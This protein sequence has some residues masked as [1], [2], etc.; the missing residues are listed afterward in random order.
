MK[1]LYPSFGVLLVDDEKPWLRSLRIALERN[2]GINNIYMCDDSREVIPLL[3]RQS[4]G[5]IL[6][7]LTMPYLTGEKLLD[8]INKDFP[9]ITVIIISGMNQLEIA[10]Q[11]MKNGA[12]DYF[13][14]TIEEERLIQGVRHAIQMH[15]LTYCQREIT[16]RLLTGKLEN[17]EAFS[18]IITKN[19][20]MFSIFQYIEAI[21][22]TNQPVLIT[23]E[24]GSGKELVSQALHQLSQKKGKLVS[25][26][27]AGLDDNVFA[28]TLFGHLK[29][30][31]TGAD[32]ARKGIIEEATGGTL[33]LD[34][35][36]DLSLSSQVK[37]LRLLQEGEYFPLGSD[38]AKRSSVRVILA[39]HKDLKKEQEAGRFRKDLY[40]RL[41]THHVHI[42]ALRDRKDD[43]P[44]LLDHFLKEASIELKKTKPGYPR[45]LAVLLS[46]HNFPGNIRELRSLVF[47]ALSLNKTKILSM[48]TFKHLITPGEIHTTTTNNEEALGNP[49]Q[50]IEPLPT[51][52]QNNVLLIREAMQ[53]TEGNQSI[54]SRMLGISQPALSKRLKQLDTDR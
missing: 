47:N 48:E 20:H 51:L 37:L 44:I 30:A 19:H 23:G 28:D 15:E 17:P 8:L 3:K 49:F 36:G 16:N 26:N 38:K 9:D 29:G 1:E 10:V 54:A 52:A 41:C 35:I 24:S 14:K 6:L 5:L 7:D 53:R 21:A 4:I 22:K 33:L 12:Y 45:E 42:P 25:V 11:C 27:I 32:N 46:N 31:Y 40:Y 50:T 13:V 34:E 43:V 39:T 2:G 18:H